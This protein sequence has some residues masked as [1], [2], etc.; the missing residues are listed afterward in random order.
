MINKGFV[1]LLLAHAVVAF[2]PLGRRGA[3]SSPICFGIPSSAHPRV[4]EHQHGVLWDTRPQLP[5]TKYSTL[6]LRMEPTSDHLE[7]DSQDQDENNLVRGDSV[8][9]D[10]DDNTL[11]DDP[12]FAMA[13]ESSL[14]KMGTLMNDHTVWD[15]HTPS[16]QRLLNFCKDAIHVS[17]STIPGAGRGLFATKHIQA[18]TIV[19]FYPVHGIGVDLGG[20]NVAIASLEEQ[21]QFYFDHPDNNNNEE[22]PNYRQY[23]LGNRPLNGYY[24][25]SDSLDSSNNDNQKLPLQKLF[26]DI[27][28]QRPLHPG[29][30]SHCLNDGAVVEE[31]SKQGVVT[32][33]KVSFQQQNCLQIPFGPAPI[34]ATVTTRTVQA[35]DELFASYGSAYWLQDL[36]L[37]DREGQPSLPMTT[38]ATRSSDIDSYI[39]QSASDL[40]SSIQLVQHKYQQELSSLRLLYESL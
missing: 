2:A 13:I 25:S 5:R 26:I 35:G 28:P 27:N 11:L 32:Y 16:L 3:M 19:S 38:A 14:E 10:S 22:S 23:L 30:M 37:P 33:Y 36:L 1:V 7:N 8:T 31:Y 17:P 40:R 12:L 9:K 20:P 21:D 34:M 15:R 4:L 39:Q 24:F 18:G 6:A 29:W